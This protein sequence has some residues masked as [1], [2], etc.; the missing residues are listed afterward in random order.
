MMKHPISNHLLIGTMPRGP[1]LTLG[2]SH[3]WT[4]YYTTTKRKRCQRQFFT[5]SHIL[6]YN[7]S[8]FSTDVKVQKKKIIQTF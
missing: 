7:S 2:L 6:N 8:P 1:S 5:Q 3:E 4:I